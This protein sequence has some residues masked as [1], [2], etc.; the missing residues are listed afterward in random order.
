MF[1]VFILSLFL[2]PALNAGAKT[3]EV[4]IENMKFNPQEIFVSAGDEVVWINNDLVPHTITGKALNSP[5]ISPNQRWAF[6]AKKKGRFEY[7][8]SLH[9]TMLGSLVVR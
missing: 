9:P 6:S 8:C 5:V 4:K 3:I 1:R 2:L 7:A